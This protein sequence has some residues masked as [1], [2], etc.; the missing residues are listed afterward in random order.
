MAGT[1][2]SRPPRPRRPRHLCL[3]QHPQRLL[4][5][6]KHLGVATHVTRV[7]AG[8]SGLRAGPETLSRTC[9]SPAYA[10]LR[11]AENRAAS[12]FY[13][14]PHRRKKTQVRI[15][16]RY[17]PFHYLPKQNPLNEQDPG[18]GTDNFGATLA[19]EGHHLQASSCCVCGAFGE[20]LQAGRR[21]RLFLA[22]LG[23]AL[24]V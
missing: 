14:L 18:K 24:G 16:S 17:L 12:Y 22:C 20:L 21:W 19:A 1:S 10:C 7:N 13:E 4:R 9:V 6:A 2:A 5:D 3:E 11:P 8:L 23:L 15:P